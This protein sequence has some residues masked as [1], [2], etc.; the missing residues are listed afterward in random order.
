MYF[1]KTVKLADDIK[2]NNLKL[3]TIP[4]KGNHN[5]SNISAAL[6]IAKIYNIDANISKHGFSTKSCHTCS[7]GSSY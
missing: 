4:L 6:A 2:N 3:D 7:S 5:Y 1:W